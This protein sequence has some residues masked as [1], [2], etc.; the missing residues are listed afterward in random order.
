[1]A[2]EPNPRVFTIHGTNEDG[3]AMVRLGITPFDLMDER[4]RGGGGAMI[5]SFA[6]RPLPLVGEGTGKREGGQD[7]G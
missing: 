7:P 3:S 6:S 5:S 2:L 1:V 4:S